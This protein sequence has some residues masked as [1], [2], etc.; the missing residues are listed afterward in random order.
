[1]RLIDA[2]KLLENIK[3]I[4]SWLMQFIKSKIEEMPKYIGIELYS[5]KII[6]NELI[7]LDA[8]VIEFVKRELAKELAHSIAQDTDFEEVKDA[9]T[10]SYMIT[11]RLLNC[12]RE[13][14]NNDKQ[15]NAK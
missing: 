11:G 8:G 12:I 7:R 6:P 13:E 1:M 10:D 9:R 14:K 2:D 15:R 3:D 4:P 5:R